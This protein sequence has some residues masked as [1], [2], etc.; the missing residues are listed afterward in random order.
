MGS[1]YQISPAAG[2]EK[3]L[4]DRFT[5]GAQHKSGRRGPKMEQG[6]SVIPYPSAEWLSTSSSFISI[7]LLLPG[8]PSQ[9]ERALLAPV[10]PSVS[11]KSFV[12]SACISSC[13][14]RK[15]SKEGPIDGSERPPRA[16][17]VLPPSVPAIRRRAGRNSLLLSLMMSLLTRATGSDHVPSTGIRAD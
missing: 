5:T 4:P 9:I 2:A 8:P 16:G 3:S 1:T 10:P 13:S 7:R 14:T 17:F 6:K 11:R 15:R 12:H